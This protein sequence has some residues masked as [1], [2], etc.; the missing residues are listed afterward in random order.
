MS[1]YPCPKWRIWWVSAIVSSAVLAWSSLAGAQ[2]VAEFALPTPGSLPYGIAAGADGALW[3]TEYVV[4]GDNGAPNT[5]SAIGRITTAG[6]IT[7][8]PLPSAA[9]TPQGIAAGPDG[10]LWFI[11]TGDT[12]STPNV[13]VRI[14]RITTSGALT[15][16]ALPDAVD[17]AAPNGAIAAGSD[18][19]LWYTEV[20]S[21]FATPAI[22]S[23]IGRIALDGTI[24]EF[25]LPLVYLYPESIAP[26]P[27]GALWFAEQNVSEPGVNAGVIGRIT[28]SGTVTQ[29]NLDHFDLSP[30]G[31]AAGPDGALWFAEEFSVG[32]ISTAGAVTEYPISTTPVPGGIAAGPDGALWFFETADDNPSLLIGRLTTGGT[33][34]IF[35]RPSGAGAPRSI[36]AGPD[37]AMWF[38]D[39]TGGRIGRVAP[40]ASTSPLVAA[41]LPSSRSV[42][43]GATATAFATIINGGTS[44]LTSCGIVPVTGMPADFLYQ[45]TDPATNAL[46]GAANVPVSI[47]GRGSQSFF[48]AFTVN[49]PF[50]P[51]DT[52]L[53][54]DCAG[55]DAAASVSGLNTVL[56]SG[57]TVPVPDVIALSAT[58]SGDGILD[59]AGPAGSASFAVATANI[60]AAGALTVIAD[61]G[62]AALPVVLSLCATDPATAQCLAPPTTS[63]ATTIDTGA[64]PTFS[65]FAEAAGAIPFMPDTGRIFVRFIDADGTTRGA[66]SV[67][68]RTQ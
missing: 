35:P 6:A 23:K 3:F 20:G 33:N 8:F 5:A 41:V 32:R 27:D 34:S 28:T 2:A 39:F 49:A 14:G 43:I 40:L 44:P 9:S 50:V 17:A 57:S 47:A 65:I 30:F 15:E 63:L 25:P 60:G 24:T 21:A 13:P 61:T 36:V 53:G 1:A 10:A 51:T 66:T 22:P 48:M 42:E 55:A 12:N 19:A 54:F 26:G 45:T 29:F 56:L 11:E 16:F 64:T 59:I 52:V 7:E 31:I 62:A 4:N 18:G 67:A 37:G 58:A 46:T 68:V 38:T